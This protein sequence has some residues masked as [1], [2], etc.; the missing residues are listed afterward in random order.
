GLIGFAFDVPDGGIPSGLNDAGLNGSEIGKSAL[1]NIFDQNPGMP[2]FFTLSLSRNGD[3]GGTAD[4]DITI[5]EYDAR[6]SEVQQ[7]PL[8][9]IF[10]TGAWNILMDGISV[11]GV[12][13]PW[14]RDPNGTV[15]EGKVRGLLDSGTTGIVAPSDIVDAIYSSIPGAAQVPQDASID[16][17]WVI[18]CNIT[19]DLHLTFGGQN[20]TVHPLDVSDL[21]VYTTLDNKTFTVCSGSV[22]PVP[23]MGRDA[24]FGTSFLRNV[25]TVFGFGNATHAPYAQ[26]LSVVNESA[27]VADFMSVRAPLLAAGKP[28]ELSPAVAVPILVKDE[29]VRSATSALSSLT[30]SSTSASPSSPPPL[31]SPTQS[32]PSVPNLLAPDVSS[33]SNLA[34]LD[35]AADTPSAPPDSRIS[36]YAPIVI[37]LLG[38]NLALLLFLLVLG[39]SRIVR[40]GRDASAGGSRDVRYTRVELKES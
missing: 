20:F 10:G 37:G 27:V 36:R 15:P 29:K 34:E 23:S 4:G 33:G 40:T 18:P 6:Y 11:N 8:L 39:V 5:G 1:F 30:A 9:P 3:Q 16:G 31:S 22:R 28:H 26:M 14:A 35:A 7:A 2:R 19:I 12:E 24:I 13:I 17:T 21:D 38:A 25:Y 32:A